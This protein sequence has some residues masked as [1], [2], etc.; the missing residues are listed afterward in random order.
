MK[1]PQAASAGVVVNLSPQSVRMLVF[2]VAWK[3]AFVGTLMFLIWLRGGAVSNSD[4][5]YSSGIFESF[6][7]AREPA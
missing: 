6:I 1:L 4:A 2:I 3:M 5:L 7:A